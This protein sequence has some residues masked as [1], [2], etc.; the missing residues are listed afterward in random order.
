MNRLSKRLT[1]PAHDPLHAYRWK[2]DFTLTPEPAAGGQTRGRSVA[3]KPL[4]LSRMSGLR[5]DDVG[6]NALALLRCVTR[7]K[8]PSEQIAAPILP[9]VHS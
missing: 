5:D 1:E 6:R 9:N 3:V 4:A 2:R 8:C 7:D